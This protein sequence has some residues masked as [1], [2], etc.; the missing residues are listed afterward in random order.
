MGKRE[1][2]ALAT[3][4]AIMK[5][6]SDLIAERGYENVVVEDITKR[7]GIAKGTFYNYYKQKDDVLTEF[8][9]LHFAEINSKVSEM[10]EFDSVQTAVSYYLCNYINVLKNT[11]ITKVRHWLTLIVLPSTLP[12][13]YNSDLEI[14][15]KLL[16]RAKDNGLLKSDAAVEQLANVIVTY[17]YG[18]IITWAI[19]DQNDPSQKIELFNTKVLPK[20]LGP[21][22]D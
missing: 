5:A 18:V 1:E 17:L 13:K 14:I 21:Y 10:K 7:A 11:G 20:V 2:N 22:L 8:A 15:Y 6:T 4:K 16:L 12:K 3:K 19:N 9:N